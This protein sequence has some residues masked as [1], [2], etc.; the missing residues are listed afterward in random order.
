MEVLLPTPLRSL[1]QWKWPRSP[2]VKQKMQLQQ[3]HITVLHVI[4]PKGLKPP[5]AELVPVPTP[6]MGQHHMSSIPLCT[7]QSAVRP[8]PLTTPQS[9]LGIQQQAVHRPAIRHNLFCKIFIYISQLAFSMVRARPV[10]QYLVIVIMFIYIVSLF[11][12]F[13]T[14]LKISL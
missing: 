11:S 7:K 14:C 4:D 2:R 10:I 9:V 12:H 13:T 6:S 3:L 1:R 8:A 5:M